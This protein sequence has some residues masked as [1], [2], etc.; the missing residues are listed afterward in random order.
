[1]RIEG[2]RELAAPRQ[3][4]FDALTDPE[5]V[6]QTMPGLQDL[7]VADTD[8]WTASVKLSI[9]PRLKMSF[10]IQERRE[11]EHGRLHAH[12][13]NFGSSVTIDTSFDLAERDGRTLMAYVAEFRLGG[14]LGRLG[15]AALRP[16]AERQVERLI[17]AVE[18]RVGA[19]S[20]AA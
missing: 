10:E 6:A 5:L 17:G 20:A 13:K 19:S 7:R 14:I 16:L 4:V 12:G 1:M 2:N 18:R 8:H 3:A 15:E 9:A 11:P